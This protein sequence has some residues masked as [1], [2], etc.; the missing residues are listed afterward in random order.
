MGTVSIGYEL[1]GGAITTVA[2]SGVSDI[3]STGFAIHAGNFTIVSAGGLTQPTLPSPGL[4]FSNN[5]DVSA[6]VRY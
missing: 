5:T 2:G 1:D 6:G 3:F 4:L